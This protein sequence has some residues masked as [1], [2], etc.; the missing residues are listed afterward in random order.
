LVVGD[1]PS[2]DGVFAGRLAV[3][4]G[5]VLSGV[6]PAGAPPPDPQAAKSA[7]DLPSLIDLFLDAVGTLGS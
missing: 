5:L 7:A 4:F 3:P 1:R 2:T 6:T